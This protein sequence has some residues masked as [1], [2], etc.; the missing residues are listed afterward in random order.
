MKKVYE[1]FMAPILVTDISSAGLLNTARN[2]FLALKFRTSTAVSGIAKRV[3]PMWKSAD[4]IGMDHVSGRDFSNAG[5]GYGGS[6]SQRHCGVHR[7]SAISSERH[8]ICSGSATHKR[9]SKGAFPQTIR[10]TLWVLREKRIAIWGLTFKPDTDDVRLS[11]A[12]DW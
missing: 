5:I 1:P 10:E 12:I 2:S 7:G 4:G 9:G 8:S 11:V 6:C 3:E